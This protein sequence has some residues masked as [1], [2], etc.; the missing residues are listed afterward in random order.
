MSRGNLSSKLDILD[1]ADKGKVLKELNGKSKE[2]LDLLDTD[3]GWKAY[4][5]A[6]NLS[7]ELRLN[8][9]VF[10]EIARLAQKKLANGEFLDV[11][12]LF[13][14]GF[15]DLLK[16]INE[17]EVLRRMKRMN[18]WDPIWVDDLAKN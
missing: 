15:S 6:K 8:P 10:D 7:P 18:E 17:A 4:R 2:R 14:N 13:E 5:L 3:A 11:Q 1:E 16:N 12:K 9:D